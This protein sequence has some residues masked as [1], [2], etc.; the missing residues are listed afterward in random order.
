MALPEGPSEELFSEDARGGHHSNHRRRHKEDSGLIRVS[1]PFANTLD[2]LPILSTGPFDFCGVAV[3]PSSV[4]YQNLTLKFFLLCSSIGE[5]VGDN[6]LHAALSGLVTNV[7]DEITSVVLFLVDD[8]P[9]L[10][11]ELGLK[12][13]T[14]RS[15]A[16]SF[17]LKCYECCHFIPDRFLYF[18]P[19]MSRYRS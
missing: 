15:L 10:V 8:L 17:K 2:S 7:L 12:A 3:A 13:V 18:I 5:L 14:F 19:Q 6:L 1:H 9:P 4:F 16:L 11:V